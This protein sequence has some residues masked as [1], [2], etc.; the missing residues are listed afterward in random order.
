[1]YILYKGEGTDD[2]MHDPTS[3]PT[4]EVVE[5]VAEVAEV[6]VLGSSFDS[7][8]LPPPPAVTELK[9]PLNPVRNLRTRSPSDSIFELSL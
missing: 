4:N 5:D 9:I 2:E 3:S 6:P 1:M 7:N 8:L